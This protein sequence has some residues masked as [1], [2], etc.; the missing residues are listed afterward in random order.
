MTMPDYAAWHSAGS[1]R[2]AGFIPP[3]TGQHRQPP[4]AQFIPVKPGS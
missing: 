1:R 4:A 2:Q 3:Y